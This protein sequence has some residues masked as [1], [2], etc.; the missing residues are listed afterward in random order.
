M[1]RSFPPA[2]RRQAKSSH[3]QFRE[4][5]FHEA[6][7]A[8]A[9]YLGNR[10]KQ[11]PP[12]FFQ[13]TL[14]ES[15]NTPSPYKT[16]AHWSAEIEGGCL[17]QSLPPSA[18]EITEHFSLLERKGFLKALEADI[19]NLLVGP[20]AEANYV[21]LR[22]DEII[23]SYLVT[24]NSL[25]HYGG[26]SDLAKVQD[27]IGYLSSIKSEQEQKLSRLFY[28]AFRFIN[29]RA[30]WRAITALANHILSQNKNVI[31]YDEII[32][33]LDSNHFSH[34]KNP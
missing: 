8:A 19:F 23:N 31:G 7:H 33:V 2:S 16:G 28:C 6:G 20:L 12:V 10:L 32:A 4:T 25:S 29:D 5:A 17:I 11:L 9:I 14:K 18:A 30:V 22:D 24:V 3:E 34:R 21:A 15:H 27:H 1:Q 26:S 13:I